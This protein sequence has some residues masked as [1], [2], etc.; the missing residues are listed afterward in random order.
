M[1]T[2]TS[3]FENLQDAFS[4]LKFNYIVNLAGYINHDLISNGGFSIVQSQINL[5][6]NLVSLFN[7]KK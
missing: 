7:V 3:N 6:N 4:D 2:D 1:I 5:L